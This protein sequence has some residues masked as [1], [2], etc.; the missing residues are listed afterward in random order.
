MPTLTGH[1]ARRAE[2]REHKHADKQEQGP[3]PTGETF[4][5]SGEQLHQEEKPQA[6][7]Q[8]ANKNTHTKVHASIEKYPEDEGSPEDVPGGAAYRVQ[9]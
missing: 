4:P 9:A 8:A 5:P 1:S 3:L 6:G 2:G 7:D